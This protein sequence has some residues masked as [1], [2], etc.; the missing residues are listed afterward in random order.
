MAGE[1]ACADLASRWVS[2]KTAK[3]R[4]LFGTLHNHALGRLLDNT[5]VMQHLKCFSAQSARLALGCTRNS[6]ATACLAPL[7]AK[8]PVLLSCAGAWLSWPAQQR[9]PG[10]A[11]PPPPLI[12]GS[13]SLLAKPHSSP[14]AAVTA[15]HSTGGQRTPYPQPSAPAIGGSWGRVGSGT[16]NRQGRSR[17]RAWKPSAAAAAATPHKQRAGRHASCHCP[18]QPLRSATISPQL[19]VCNL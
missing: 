18:N 16:D 10:L 3:R 17:E 2:Q 9:H 4:R 19:P 12:A 11:P 7:K 14:A 8:P 6:P 1:G 5:C 15:G 13:S